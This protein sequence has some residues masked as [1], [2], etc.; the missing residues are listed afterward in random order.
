MLT[1][2]EIL[3]L[4]Q[5]EHEKEESAAG[6]T[7]K[8]GSKQSN[9]IDTMSESVSNIAVSS[10]VNKEKSKR[11]QKTWTCTECDFDNFMYRKTCH[12]CLLSKESH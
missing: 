4:M 9:C 8:S 3:V 7:V 1:P 10:K 11:K 5:A 6:A 12:F 2:D